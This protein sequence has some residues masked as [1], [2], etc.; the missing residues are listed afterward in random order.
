MTEHIPSGHPNMTHS[1][2][3]VAKY[4]ETEDPYILIFTA[5]T[6]LLSCHLKL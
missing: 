6:K 3:V 2:G 4:I 1:F 5:K